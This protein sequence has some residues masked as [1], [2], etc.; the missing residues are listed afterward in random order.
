MPPEWTEHHGIQAANGA[1]KQTTNPSILPARHRQHV[2]ACGFRGQRQ[3]IGKLGCCHHELVVR[4]MASESISAH[5]GA[6]RRLP[7]DASGPHR[8][9]ERSAPMGDSRLLDQASNGLQCSAGKT[10]PWRVD[11]ELRKE[12]GHQAAIQQLAPFS[13][14]HIDAPTNAGEPLFPRSVAQAQLTV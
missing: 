1:L 5:L 2:A 6:G 13:G 3:V 9:C 10:I 14:Q 12:A 4:I 7:C 11:G 8:C